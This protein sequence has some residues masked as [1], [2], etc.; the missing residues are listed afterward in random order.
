MLIYSQ[1]AQARAWQ[2]ARARAYRMH[3]QIIAVGVANRRDQQK[4][5]FIAFMVPFGQP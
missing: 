5:R 2:R 3:M 1:H 4:A